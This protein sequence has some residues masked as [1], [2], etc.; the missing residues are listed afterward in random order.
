VEVIFQFRDI[1]NLEINIL[2]GT[3]DAEAILDRSQV[4]V[5][6]LY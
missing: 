3:E 1:G 6:G 2:I 4:S 5:F